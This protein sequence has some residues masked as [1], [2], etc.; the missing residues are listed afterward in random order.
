VADEARLRRPTKVTWLGHSTVLVDS[1][2]VRMLTDPLLRRRLGHVLR[3]AG[4]Y[5]VAP[6]VDAVLVSHVH[7]DHL[8][9]PSLRSVG[10]RC[11]VVP[12]GA[13]GL[14][15]G[16]LGGNVVELDEGDELSLG[17]LAVRA[18]HAEHDG[19]R[20][21]FARHLPSLGY[22]LIG[23]SRVY[24]AGDTDL[25]GGMRDLAPLDLALLPIAGWGPRVGPGHLD[26][27]SAAEALRLLR[28]RMAI[29]IHWGTYRRVGMSRDPAAL[30]A[31]AEAFEMFAADLAPEVQ[32]CTLSPGEALS[33]Q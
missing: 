20:H 16:R 11:V 18:T 2:G 28:P 17:P 30:R 7:Y 13:R 29:P 15:D 8:D 33:I 31:P 10:A 3:V 22:L 9:L 1:A 12:R 25:F 27:R 23:Q 32:I 6:D 5:V 14:V 21:P 4:R 19:R 26:A 24:F